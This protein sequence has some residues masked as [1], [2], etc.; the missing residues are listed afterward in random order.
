MKHLHMLAAVITLLLF[1]YQAGFVFSSKS[2]TLSKGFKIV[3]HL[4]YTVLVAT[5][6]WIFWQLYQLVGLQ[7]WAVAKIVLL[8]VAVS[9]NIKSIRYQKINCSQAKA[10]MLIAA[11]AYAGILILAFTKPMLT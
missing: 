4:V 8:I 5:G 7:H 2:V 3:S 1:L 11:V 9:A 10:G 6:L